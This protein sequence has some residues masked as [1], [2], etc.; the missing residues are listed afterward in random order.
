MIEATEE[1]G[2]CDREYF[3]DGYKI[4]SSPQVLGR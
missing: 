3:F 1:M 4:Y 2:R